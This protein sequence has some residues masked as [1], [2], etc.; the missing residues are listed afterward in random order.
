VGRVTNSL[1]RQLA[2]YNSELK[3]SPLAESARVLAELLDDG[4]PAREASAISREFRAI[5]TELRERDSEVPASADPLDEIAAR[6]Q[7]RAAGQ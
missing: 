5:L 4:P 7:R 6:R 2:K 3:E 1:E